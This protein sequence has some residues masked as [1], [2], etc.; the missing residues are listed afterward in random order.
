MDDVRQTIAEL[1]VTKT[2]KRPRTDESW[3]DL[4]IDSIA[5]AEIV[6]ELEQHIGLRLNEQV[7]ETENIDELAELIDQLR[8]RRLS[9]QG[10]VNPARGNNS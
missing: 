3:W 10:I 9:E 2:G 5:M 7:F 1:I 4:D 6:H 8:A